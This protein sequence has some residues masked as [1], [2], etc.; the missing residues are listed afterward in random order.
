MFSLDIIVIFLVFLLWYTL[1]FILIIDVN[2]YYGKIGMKIQ[3]GRLKHVAIMMGI[4]LSGIGGSGSFT[5]TNALTFNFTPATGTSQQAI[6]GFAQAGSL[7]SSLFTDN[8]TVNI[9]IDFSNLGGN[10]LGSASTA[11]QPF[12]YANVYNALNKDRKSVDDKSAVN[13][14]ANSST[15]NMLLNRTSNNP[16]GAG[17]ATTYLD[18]NGNDNNRLLEVGTANAKALGLIGGNN[19]GLDA[20]ISF[21]NQYA[22]DFDRRNGISAGNFDFIGIAAHEI[23]HALGFFSGVDTLINNSSNGVFFPDSAFTIVT[24]LDL[25][26]YSI[27]SKNAK[28]RDNKNV[29]DFTADSRDKYF[30][31]D[32]GI[33]KIAAFETGLNKQASHWL[34]NGGRGIMDP[35]TAS[36]EL[37][38]ITENDLRAFDAIGWDR[39]ASSYLSTAPY[40]ATAVPEPSNLLGTCLFA[41]F[42]VRT[43]IKRKQKL[44]KLSIESEASLES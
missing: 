29:I 9:N 22:W 17:S 12:S 39:S 20:S 18:N 25:F 19:T 5:P 3:I 11:L 38:A 28:T 36:G 40:G 30:S 10:T 42:G 23:G 4:A 35:T 6:N 32:G 14:L 37:L 44:A 41:A 16:N 7:W 24:P 15:F 34:D 13:S 33:T 27:N 31:L 2:I 1:T 8:V 26:R 21:S 43:I